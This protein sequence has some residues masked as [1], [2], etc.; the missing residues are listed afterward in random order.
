MRTNENII[1]KTY[2]RLLVQ[3]LYSAA[4]RRVLP[5]TSPSQYCQ[6]GLFQC[7]NSCFK[8]FVTSFIAMYS[9][10]CN[11]YISHGKWNGMNLHPTMGVFNIYPSICSFSTVGQSLHISKIRENL[12]WHVHFLCP[13]LHQR[14]LKLNQ[15]KKRAIKILNPTLEFEMLENNTWKQSWKAEKLSLHPVLF[16]HIICK[17]SNV[18]ASQRTI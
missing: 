17:I 13:A 4:K 8:C 2:I 10:A 5:S 1:L 7:F 11:N 15:Y 18:D 3:K 6:F 14:P 9:P 12:A 16:L